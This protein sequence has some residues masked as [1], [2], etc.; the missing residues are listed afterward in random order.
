MLEKQIIMNNKDT[1]NK[2][3]GLDGSNCEKAERAFEHALD[4]RKFEIELYWKRATYFW[5]LIAV[6]FAGFFSVLSTQNLLEK[7][8]YAFV[9]GVI[10]LV[11]TWAWFLVNKGSK[12]WQENW[13][14]HVGMLED[15]V[16][17]PL[18]KTILSRPE[19]D[20]FIEKHIIGPQKISVSKINQWVS[21]F[22]LLIWGSLIFNVIPDFNASSK[23]SWSHVIV[24]IVGLVSCYMMWTKGKSY[25]GPH[26]H[27]MKVRETKIK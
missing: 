3:F 4:T 21:L 25:M 16:T 10:G 15:S 17:G 11:F 18:F 13:E 7:E 5:A 2:N 26:S 14:N 20:D 12:F 6:A 9:I 19:E 24:M 27:I 22:T 23:I 1:Y 8:F